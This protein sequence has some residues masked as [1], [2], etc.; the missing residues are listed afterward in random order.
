[1]GQQCDHWLS[2]NEVETIDTYKLLHSCFGVPSFDGVFDTVLSISDL[3][4]SG[5]DVIMEGS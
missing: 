2:T 4:H 5:A 3:G 1:M